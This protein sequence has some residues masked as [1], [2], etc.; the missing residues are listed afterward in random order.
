MPINTTY[1][2]YDLAVKKSTRVRD[3]AGGEDDVK[4]KGEIYLPKLGGQTQ[5]DYDDFLMRGYLIPAVSP[6]AIAIAG[7]IMRKPA[8]FEPD[9]NLDYM[10]E[11]VDGN[12]TDLTQFIGNMIK[13]LL[14]AGAAG[15]LVEYTDKAVVK[16]YTKESIINVS[17]D[18]I[19]LSQEYKEQDPKDKYIQL[20]KTEYLELT[21]DEAGY[22]IQNLWREGDGKKGFAIVDTFM[23]TNRGEPLDRIPFVFTNALSD[24]PLLL[25]LAN[26]N[27]KQYLQST[28]QSHGLHWT[29]LATLF[30]FGDL[31]DESGNKKQ[32][33]VG[34][35]SANHIEDVEARVEM[36]TFDGQGMSELRLSITERTQT[37]A[38]IGAKML[39]DGSGGVKSAETS[40]IEASSETATLSMIANTVDN[41]MQSLLE[42]IAEW[43]GSSIP[44][45][46]V[47]KDF[48]DVNLDPQTLLAYLQVYQ[49][50]GMSLNSFL[51]LL[52]KGELLPKGITAEDEADRVETTGVDFEED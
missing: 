16:K 41:T 24:D 34:V 36:L 4:G 42:I 45:Y 10:I 23:P 5:S 15:Y 22:Y 46:A 37:M 26:V 20:T 49:S 51:N 1:E 2:G 40:R 43:Q 17:D 50:G 48:I 3:F 30:L 25:H 38:S 33:K 11:D 18:Y 44:E 6:T 31:R 52:V 29:A 35:G 7:A 39:F 13:E 27:H 9:S 21:Y 32:I 14:Y 28:D 19:V 47:N 12:N 8:V